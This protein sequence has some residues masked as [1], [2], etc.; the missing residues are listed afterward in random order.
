MRKNLLLV[1]ATAV[2][3]M[4]CQNYDDQ[5]NDLNSQ[6]TAL[7]TQVTGLSKVQTDLTTLA[8]T[9]GSLQTSITGNGT[10]LANGLSSLQEQ[11]DALNTQ[12]SA[13]ASTEDVTN[14]NNALD[15]VREDLDDLL[16]SSNVFNGDLTIT[17]A[18][19]LEFAQSLKGK[20][21]IINGNV[22]IAL[23]AEMDTAALQEVVGQI[24]TITKD[25]TVRAQSSSAGAV[26][27]DALTGV[28]NLKIAQPGSIEFPVLKSA[29]DI[30][31]GKNYASKLTGAVDFGAMEQVKSFSTTTVGPAPSYTLGAGG[32]NIIDLSKISTL[33]LG[34][35]KH[36]VPSN[37]TINTDQDTT[38]NLE[39]LKSAD[40][41]GKDKK[42]ALAVNGA[43]ALNIPGLVLGSVEVTDV[44]DVT[45]NAF[46]GTVTVRSGVENVTVGA[47]K[48]SFTAAAA[49]DLETLNLTM[50]DAV[51]KEINLEEAKSL[52]SVEISGK[53]KTIAL[54]NNSDLDALAIS[55]AV[56][57][58]TIQNTN[59]SV[60]DLAYTN[61][62]LAE[63]GTL[64]IIGNTDLTSFSANSVNGLALL[65]ITGNTDLETISFNALKAVPT[66][67]GKATVTIGG[68]G[69]AN[70]LN[71]TNIV[72]DGA[73]SADGTFTSDSGISTLKTF[74]TE[75]AKNA[76]SVLKVYFDAADDFTDGSNT[77][78]GIKISGSSTEVG[79]LTVIN[80][81]SSTGAAKSK[82]ALLVSVLPDTTLNGEKLN[83]NGTEI[84]WDRG[85][86]AADF[87]SNLMS[88][89]NVEQL[90]N[91]GVTLTANANGSPTA[92]VTT[93]S[94]EDAA[95]TGVPSA[96]TKADAQKVVLTIGDYSS[97]IYITKTALADFET[98]PIDATDKSAESQLIVSEGV[99][100]HLISDVLDAIVA[101]FGS[102]N[103]ITDSPYDVENSSSGSSSGTLSITA[104]DLSNAQ[105]GKAVSF[106][107]PSDLGLDA[108]VI[109][110]D[111]AEDDTLIGSNP[112]IIVESDI[113]GLTLSTIGN[114]KVAVDSNTTTL[115]AGDGTGGTGETKL[116]LSTNGEAQELFNDAANKAASMSVTNIG[117]DSTKAAK[118]TDR[119]SWLAG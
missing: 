19:T 27:F 100:N 33:N 84:M 32:S 8:G 59:L 107:A 73:G 111:V 38:L 30:T 69:N 117:A 56:E 113:A 98:D 80:R 26:T 99:S 54:K 22:T 71:A 61:S 67:D 14:I 112:V 18:A 75:A 79:Y 60:V 64:K 28:T 106:T 11:I 109:N 92:K 95:L 93:A 119:T 66:K 45:L 39:A 96:T 37:L 57:V 44:K 102:S 4:S 105:H 72:Q 13:V 83:V 17:S 115:N 78:D 62:N 63:K 108:I 10:A 1:L 23:D 85:N 42:F 46:S 118:N 87:V 103:S 43:A 25:L 110:K 34:A 36:Y 97:T 77:A 31:I 76:A 68:A 50:V 70:G 89:V 65:E 9:V 116:T 58:L 5:F 16:T 49:T 55:A 82:R 88:T 3:I 12:L 21:A 24:K 51:K 52:M 101:D 6:I 15:G 53:V 29:G 91:N 20:V 40:A 48:E 94:A 2:S 47:L 7:A 41:N 86:T 35:L 90:K 81:D 114:T 104:K 74:L